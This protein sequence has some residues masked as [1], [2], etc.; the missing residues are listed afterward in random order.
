MKTKLNT[1]AILF[2]GILVLGAAR[3]PAQ[4]QKSTSTI[5][6]GDIDKTAENTYPRAIGNEWLG[7]TGQ[8]HGYL[9]RYVK[10]FSATVQEPGIGTTP[11]IYASAHARAHL[12]ATAYV[13]K[14]RSELGRFEA[15]GDVY[16]RSTGTSMSGN[17]RL[18][19]AG[20]TVVSN[21]FSQNTSFPRFERY[22]SLFAEDPRVDIAVGPFTLTLKG[23]AGVGLEA[24]GSAILTPVPSVG[25][26]CFAQAWGLAKA[27]VEFGIL[28]FGVGAEVIGKLAEQTL[29]PNFTASKSGLSGSLEY[30]MV[31][32]HL[33]VK[34]Y[35]YALIK[36]W[37]TTILDKEWG[38]VTKMLIQL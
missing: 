36:K 32:L 18:R 38:K 16:A 25:I 13:L 37:S 27:N 17:Y 33:K 7:L 3:A 20:L 24:V 8:A 6:Q 21:S 29:A 12:T 34:A 14:S 31:A 9:R 2:S 10:G 26:T 15:R 5:Q 28:G 11:D 22:V 23:N 30:V 1:F 35:V 4:F 19:L